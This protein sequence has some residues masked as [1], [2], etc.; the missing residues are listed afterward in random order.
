MNHREERIVNRRTARTVWMAVVLF[1]LCSASSISLIAQSNPPNDRVKV[2][3]GFNQ[4]PGASGEALVRA[5]GGT[6]KHNYR[7]IPAIAATLPQRAV[8][9]LENH[10][11]VSVIEPDVA[12][13]ALDDYSNV[14]GVSKIGA[15][16]VHDAGNKGFG[17]KV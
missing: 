8:Q 15:K 4:Q 11:L 7:I 13:Y 9:A 1:L 6:V 17:R 14:W 2:I 10:P 12:V 5:F 3:I 16:A